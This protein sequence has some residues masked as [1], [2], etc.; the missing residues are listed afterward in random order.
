MLCRAGPHGQDYAV[1]LNS[2]SSSHTQMLDED[3]WGLCP[4]G[5]EFA[6]IFLDSLCCQSYDSFSLK[7]KYVL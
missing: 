7:W 6:W 5:V 2:L 4:I 1:P 3:L